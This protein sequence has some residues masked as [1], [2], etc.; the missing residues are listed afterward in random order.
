MPYNDIIGSIGVG[1]ILLAYFLKSFRLI[2]DGKFFYSLNIFGAGMAC[3]A[4][5]LIQYMP[6]VIL[7]AFGF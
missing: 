1:S 5:Y 6:F 2:S 7:E 4:S 3:Y